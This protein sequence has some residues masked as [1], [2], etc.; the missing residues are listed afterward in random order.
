VPTF[1]VERS[2]SSSGSC[3]ASEKYSRRSC[4]LSSTHLAQIAFELDLTE[5]VVQLADPPQEVK[6]NQQPAPEENIH[7]RQKN[8]P[9]LQMC[10]SGPSLKL[11]N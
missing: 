6:G 4:T 8:S 7:L 11:P 1:C 2:I 10:L 3:K 5:P 9:F